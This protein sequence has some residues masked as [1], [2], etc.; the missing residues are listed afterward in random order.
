MEPKKKP[1]LNLAIVPST[2]LALQYVNCVNCNRHM[3]LCWDEKLGAY[4]SLCAD[5][6]VAQQLKLDDEGPRIV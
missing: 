4:F 1:A 6:R 3:F 5:C 2:Q